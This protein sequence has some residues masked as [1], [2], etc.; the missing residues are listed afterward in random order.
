MMK[1]NSNPFCQALTLRKDIYNPFYRRK[2]T[3]IK[4]F[5]ALIHVPIVLTHSQMDGIYRTMAHD[6]VLLKSVIYCI[7]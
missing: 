3:K 2:C 4:G 7:L 6:T 1:K 5:I